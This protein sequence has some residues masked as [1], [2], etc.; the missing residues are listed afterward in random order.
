MAALATTLLVLHL[1]VGRSEEKPQNALK[2]I[3]GGSYTVREKVVSS[4]SADFPCMLINATVVLSF[5]GM[6]AEVGVSLLGYRE[7]RLVNVMRCQGRCS[8]EVSCVA[9]STG[10]RTI[11]ML[12]TTSHTGAEARTE[13]QEVVLEEHLGCTCNC[14]EEEEQECSGR[15]DPS[16]CSC[17]CP[18][19]EFGEQEAA[20]EQERH[21]QWDKGSCRC[22]PRRARVSGGR[23]LLQPS[24]VV[25][26]GVD[27]QQ[28]YDPC[29]D[30]SR[31]HYSPR[32]HY[33]SL[34]IAGW[35]LL[36]SCISLVIILAGTTWHYRRKAQ[37][38]KEAQ[39]VRRPQCAKRSV[40]KK[41]KAGKEEAGRFAFHK[42]ATSRS[43]QRAN[44][45]KRIEDMNF[46]I[47]NT[48]LLNGGG[49]GDLYHEQYNEHGVKI[50]NQC[51]P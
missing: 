13:R 41:K 17:G 3:R 50:E 45:S 32:L 6:D 25:E 47:E 46:A 7:P 9:S 40:V 24:Q 26:R 39:M 33:R 29:T 21:S 27:A 11:T 30:L 43:A 31:M 12:L 10:R 36:G 48:M 49:G 4:P 18:R 14:K 16:T 20:C 2:E 34:D 51:F 35:V 8:Q 38:V 22:H 1:I 37:Q 28:Q 42:E 44:S 23:A 15:W 5:P 19:Q